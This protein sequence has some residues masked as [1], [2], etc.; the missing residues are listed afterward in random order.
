MPHHEKCHPNNIFDKVIIVSC[1]PPLWAAGSKWNQTPLAAHFCHVC[2]TVLL[3][4]DTPAAATSLV[5]TLI[6][7]PWASTTPS[8]WD[9]L[10]LTTAYSGL[11]QMAVRW[12]FL[13]EILFPA[14]CSAQEGRLKNTH[15]IKSKYPPR[16]SRHTH[17]DS[18]TSP[19]SPPT[20]PWGP[21]VLLLTITTSFS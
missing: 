20:L 9:L 4:S 16:H 21:V 6:L 12:N 14:C 13:N 11:Q 5:L 2:P 18:P 10:A 3:P 15:R 19:P 7:P 1:S 17:F 8:W